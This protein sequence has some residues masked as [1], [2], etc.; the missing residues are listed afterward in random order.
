MNL[1]RWILVLPGAVISGVIAHF[2]TNFIYVIGFT[3]YDEVYHRDLNGDTIGQS[4]F[5]II[6]GALISMAVIYAGTYVAPSN[7]NKVNNIMVYVA[8]VL[9]IIEGTVAYSGMAGRYLTF[10][11]AY[12]FHAIGYIIGCR[13]MWNRDWEYKAITK[14]KS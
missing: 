5:L 6:F 3:S 8:L 1:L 12:I 9:I 2:V 4:L 13:I 11:G 10:G 7:K 14:I